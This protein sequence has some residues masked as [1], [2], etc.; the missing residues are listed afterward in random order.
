M[1]VSRNKGGKK[2]HRK[3]S[4]QRTLMIKRQKEKAQREFHQLM[5]QAQEEAIAKQQAEQEAKE[6]ENVVGVEDIGDIGD[7]LELDLDDE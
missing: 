4:Q 5:Q 6:Q 3:R 2:A 7:G 1:P